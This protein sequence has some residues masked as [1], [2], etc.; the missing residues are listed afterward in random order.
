MTVDGSSTLS[1]ALRPDPRV[2]IPKDIWKRLAHRAVD[3]NRSVTEI[4][5][6]ACEEWLR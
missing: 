3:E 2:R 5:A 4:V 6:E 1:E